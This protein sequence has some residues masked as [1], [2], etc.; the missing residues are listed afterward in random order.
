MLLPLLFSLQAWALTPMQQTLDHLKADP[1]T[2]WRTLP[3]KSPLSSLSANFQMVPSLSKRAYRQRFFIKDDK[4][5][6]RRNDRAEALVDNASSMERSLARMEERGLLNAKLVDSPWSDSYWPLY[7]GALGA[8]YQDPYFDYED[9]WK[10]LFQHVKAQS[11]AKLLAQG[12]AAELSP[13]EKYDL[14]MGD[15]AGTLTQRMW[16]EG[17]VYYQEAGKVETWMGLC[18]GWAA[19]SFMLPTPQQT[20]MV[21]DPQGRHQFPLY[22]SDVKALGTLLYANANIP[23]RFIGSRC[24]Q[25]SPEEENGRPT[26]PDCRDTNAATWHLSVVNQIALAK[27][28]F[29]LDA[30]YDYQVWNQPVVAYKYLYFTPQTKKLAHSLEAGRVLKEQFSEDVWRARRAP[31]TK[32]IVGIMM[33]VT[34]IVE[35]GASIEASAPALPR[36][37][38]YTYDLELDEKSEIIGGEW[39]NNSHPDFLWVPQENMG[40]QALGHEMFEGWQ[41]GAALTPEAANMVKAFSAEGLPLGNVVEEIFKRSR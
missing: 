25:A 4:E 31:R 17:E 41:P 7:Q 19:A 21:K 35:N 23:S 14:L 18:H 9:D 16:Q 22:V 2:F 26:N 40:A 33:D 13:S 28:S 5:S 10:K 1:E 32:W 12:R 11:K 3:E 20:V 6:P 37:V 8:R 30:T 39:Y 36:T 27:R 34:Y 29:V 15:G 38:R 24:N